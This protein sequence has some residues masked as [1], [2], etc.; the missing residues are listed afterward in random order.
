MT[1]EL[2]GESI[3]IESTYFDKIPEMGN[4]SLLAEDSKMTVS[5]NALSGFDMPVSNLKYDIF[6]DN[7][8][9]VSDLTSTEYVKTG[10]TNGYLH[11]FVVKAVFNLTEDPTEI[12]FTVES[13]SASLSSYKN[14]D[15]PTAL[16]VS[17]L[18]DSSLILNWTAG[19]LNGCEFHKYRV[20]DGNT[21]MLESN[22]NSA[23]LVK[24]TKG[25]NYNV[26]VVTVAKRVELS[27]DI[28]LQDVV[29]V[30]SASVSTR[31]Y[32]NSSAPNNLSAEVLDRS[33]KITWTTPSDKGG[34]AIDRYDLMFIS[35]P[36]GSW[37][38]VDNVVPGHVVENLVNGT[39][40]QVRVL[41]VTNN[42]EL[43]LELNG[44]KAI[45]HA[46]PLAITTVPQNVAIEP[47]DRSM[48]ITWQAPE[49]DNGASVLQYRVYVNDVLDV[50]LDANVLTHTKTNLSN[51]LEYNIRISAMNSM[52]E[53]VK[54]LSKSVIPFGAQSIKN[55]IVSGKTVTFEVNCNGKKVDDVSVLALDASPDTKENLFI[56]SLNEQEIT[57]GHQKN[58]KT[59]NFSENI[60]KYLIIVRSDSININ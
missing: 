60:D 37:L 30:K 28:N 10:L 7:V 31:P 52:G 20:F 26:S 29:S 21:F 15:A 22:N 44:E 45:V 40:Y 25:R 50:E 32:S 41:A 56:T 47:L 24:L 48:K 57:S 43:D 2:K 27:D 18:S 54:S 49:I 38:V 13:E 5:R 58:S 14:P 35:N 59:F 42:T 4:L 39:E 3:S 46:T 6:M 8:L 53:S 16:S 23:D 12:D 34:Y 36:P 11:E 1:N 17:D 55:V 19:S 9:I 33:L 51:G